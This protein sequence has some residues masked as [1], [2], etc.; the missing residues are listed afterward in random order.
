MS[1]SP[2]YF[3]IAALYGNNT[4]MSLY[5]LIYADVP[6]EWGAFHL[7]VAYNLIEE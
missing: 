7:Q 3:E 5:I 1:T 6:C 2:Q 4:M